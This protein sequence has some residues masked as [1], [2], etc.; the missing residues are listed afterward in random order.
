MHNLFYVNI[1]EILNVILNVNIRCLRKD[2][3][4]TKTFVYKRQQRDT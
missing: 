1:A 4:N 3:I 2:V